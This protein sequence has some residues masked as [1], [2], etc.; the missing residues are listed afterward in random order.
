MLVK[1]SQSSVRKFWLISYKNGEI[2]NLGCHI[3]LSGFDLDFFLFK[4]LAAHISLPTQTDTITHV[5]SPFLDIVTTESLEKVTS[6]VGPH[7]HYKFSAVF[8]SIPSL[9]KHAMICLFPSYK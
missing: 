2:Q 6:A 9:S 7:R 8:A 4:S 5:K 1:L 3:S